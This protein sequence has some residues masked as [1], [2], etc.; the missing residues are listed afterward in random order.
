MSKVSVICILISH[1]NML[2]V[3]ALLK[4]MVSQRMLNSLDR[5]VMD[6]NFHVFIQDFT[7]ATHSFISVLACRYCL[8]KLDFPHSYI[9]PI[10][11]T[12]GIL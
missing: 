2:C 4:R 12:A 5:K 11:I 10:C 1:L 3:Q 9:G 8:L 6:S 7:G